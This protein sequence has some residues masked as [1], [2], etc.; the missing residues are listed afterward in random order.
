MRKSA[1]HILMKECKP[2]AYHYKGRCYIQCPPGTYPSAPLTPEANNNNGTAHQADID[3]IATNFGQRPL[4]PSSLRR[5]RRRREQ[6]VVQPDGLMNN[7]P[8]IHRPN[9]TTTT[10]SAPPQCLQCHTTCLKCIG[11]KATDCTEC[12]AAFRFQPI[13]SGGESRICVSI[14][15]KQRS[16]QQFSTSTNNGSGRLKTPE[17]AA[18]DLSTQDTS[19][20]TAPNSYLPS[21]LFLAG[22]LVVAVVAI[23]VLWLHCFQGTPG[24]IIGDLAGVAS[25]DGGDS[26]GGGGGGGGGGSA[27]LASIRYDRVHTNE[28]DDEEYVYEDDDDESVTSGDDDNGDLLSVSAT[29]IIAPIER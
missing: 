5:R 14:N 13:A 22:V 15:D 18:T 11:P 29:K 7:A 12:Q 8:T 20:T 2:T 4:P 25:G 24:R 1:T 23:Y 21:V 3:E 27:G 26:G 6:H 10:T 16:Q 9:F 17:S 28:Q 19:A